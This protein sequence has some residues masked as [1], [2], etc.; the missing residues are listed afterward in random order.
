MPGQPVTLD[1]TIGGGTGPY[2]FTWSSEGG[3]V[4]GTGVS[5]DGAVNLTTS[6]IPALARYGIPISTTVHLDVV[7]SM[8]AS[9]GDQIWL[10][11][12]Y[13]PLVFLPIIVRNTAMGLAAAAPDASVQ[14]IYRT[15]VEWITQYNGLNPNLS[16]TQPDGNGF[17]DSLI[18]YGWGYGPKWT[19]NSAW[20]KDWRDCSLGGIDCS[21]GMD[22][23]EFAYF[24]GHGSPARIYFGTTKDS[25]S[26]WGGNARFQTIK[27]A[28]F[29][30]C[31]TLSNSTVGD[32]FNAFQGGARVLLGFQSNMGDVAFGTPLVDNMR[33]PTFWFIG[34]LPWLQ[35]TIPQA[36]EQTAFQ[37]NAG[38]PAYLYVTGHGVDTSLDKLPRNGDPA[39]ANPYPI[40]W[41]FWVWW[42]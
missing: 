30:S 34:D 39:L 31:Q 3:T 29:S 23:A 37:M 6:A 4:L 40:E 21:L 36:W 18:G 17:Y 11:P 19:N 16:G 15:G 27:W 1:G 38:M 26:F 2:T 41:Y 33:M 32:W 7:D 8:G 28:G 20:E 42:E 10:R 25:S 22:R 35:R 5:G 12:A 9:A 24:S 13:A 14:A